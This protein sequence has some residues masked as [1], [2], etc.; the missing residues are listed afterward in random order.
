[1]KNIFSNEKNMRLSAEIQG[2]IDKLLIFVPEN[3]SFFTFWCNNYMKN[4]L[5]KTG[6]LLLVIVA[7]IMVFITFPS[8]FYLRKALWYTT[9]DIDDYRIFENRAIKA[10]N[11][12]SWKIS[13]VYNR[14]Q[15]PDQILSHFKEYRTVAYLVVQDTAIVHEEYWDGYDAASLSN[16]FSAAKSIVSL[17]AGIA[18]DEGKI[19]SFDQSVADYYPPFNT[20][21]RKEITIRD[22]LTM[23]AG[24]NW[25]EAYSSPFSVTTKAYYGENIESV[26]TDLQLVELPGVRFRYQSGVTQL[27]SFVVANATG[28]SIS[29]YASEKL[30]TPVGAEN[31]ALWSLDRKNG[32]EKAYCC[33]NSNA[34]DFARI[35]Q[36]ILN[37]GN[38]NGVQVVSEAF[39]DEA[40]QAASW[41][42]DGDTEQNVDFYGYQWW[43][44]KRNNMDVIYARG[45]L[46]QYI[47]VVPEKNMVVVRLGEKRSEVQ[48]SG[49][50]PQDVEL[51]LDAAF[52]IVKE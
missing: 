29:E 7:G 5:K 50:Y 12:Q 31:D 43:H 1:M 32:L 22:L 27:L 18:R 16:S 11:P 2:L 17:L 37:K 39:I 3:I 36:L 51:W 30:W 45:I 48:T 10:E 4:F 52:D 33:F 28:K 26:V 38:W 14:K 42:K 21:N 41:L 49:H 19:K 8:N 34:R 24:L 23:S 6:I 35:G 47:F 13:S 25:D 44:M 40:T 46:G 15:I 9:P 20:G